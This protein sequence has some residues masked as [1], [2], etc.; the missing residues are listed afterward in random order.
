[1]SALQEK[2]LRREVGSGDMQNYGDILATGWG[3]DGNVGHFL[4]IVAMILFSWVGEIR[5]MC[6]GKSNDV[7]L[8]ARSGIPG[9]RDGAPAQRDSD[10]P[11]AAE[12]ASATSVERWFSE[13]LS[14]LYAEM[15]NEPLPEELADL[16]EQMRRGKKSVA[17]KPI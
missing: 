3:T 12:P 9:V 14:R 2:Q 11:L 8:K 10:L 4:R 6:D 7:A 13:H 15:I 16:L 17:R 5:S 1:V